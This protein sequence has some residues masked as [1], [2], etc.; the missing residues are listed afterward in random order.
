[1]IVIDASA[2]IEVLSV[3]SLGKQVSDY[4]VES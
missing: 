1:M 3:G 4:L 2:I